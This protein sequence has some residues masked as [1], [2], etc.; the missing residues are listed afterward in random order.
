[1][2]W[3][4]HLFK[5]LAV[6][7]GVT[8]AAIVI[9]KLY[10]QVHRF[11]LP[12]A[13]RLLAEADDLAD[14]ANW[15]A[16]APLYQ[17]AELLF[18]QQGNAALELYARASQMPAQTE[19]SLQSMSEWLAQVDRLLNLPSARHP[20][21]RLRLLEIKGQIENNYDATLAYQ[22]WTTVEQMASQQ[23][24]LTIENRA[25]GEEAIGLFLLGDTAGAR[26]HAFRGY[27]Q[28]FLLADREGR[29]RLASLI[30]AGMV[31]YGAYGSALKYLDEALSIAQSIPHSAFP[32]VAVTA[33][34]DALR[35]LKRYSEAF[36]LSAE[37]LRVP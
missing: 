10:Q 7:V 12:P 24:N 5:V 16:A 2:R 13:E 9:V 26:K 37:A 4:I 33:K 20:K 30:G 36:A 11:L 14:R 35:G 18:H 25:Y 28:T 23:H 22:T 1:V 8:L 29:L 3:V 17:R 19:S 15:R 21:T 31:Q 32:N 6:A 34:I 27:A